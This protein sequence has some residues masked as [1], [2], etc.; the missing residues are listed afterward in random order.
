M[1]LGQLWLESTSGWNLGVWKQHAVLSHCKKGCV[2]LVRRHQQRMP[3]AWAQSQV[4]LLGRLRLGGPGGGSLGASGAVYACFAASAVLY[5]DRKAAFIFLPNVSP[6]CCLL[7]VCAH[8]VPCVAALPVLQLVR[9]SAFDSLPGYVD[10][11][12][13]PLICSRKCAVAKTQ[14][15]LRGYRISA[16]P[17]GANRHEHAAAVHDGDRRAGRPAALAHAGPSGAP[18]GRAVRGCIR[19]HR[20]RALGALARAAH[21]GRVRVREQGLGVLHEVWFIARGFGVCCN[22]A[23]AALART[24]A[25]AWGS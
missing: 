9:K 6:A 18:G 19:I 15:Y 12:L 14:V 10:S 20:H 23:G 11:L 1:L 5:P 13:S 21:A 22:S 4:S 16:R 24:E 7:C 2:H 8:F 17:A 3:R 25:G